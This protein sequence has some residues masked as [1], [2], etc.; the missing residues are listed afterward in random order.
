MASCLPEAPPVLS[1]VCVSVAV[2]VVYQTTKTMGNTLHQSLRSGDIE[3]ACCS[4][5]DFAYINSDLLPLRHDGLDDVSALKA[6]MNIRSALVPARESE[7][8]GTTHLSISMPYALDQKRLLHK[9]GKCLHFSNARCI[10]PMPFLK[11]ET[12]SIPF[13][14]ASTACLYRES[15]PLQSLQ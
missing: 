7:L 8:I 14:P 3:T 6:E 11:S 5:G 1:L 4:T 15:R 12:G 10:Q 2:F 9:H 13:G